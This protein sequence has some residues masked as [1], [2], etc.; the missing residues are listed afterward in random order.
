MSIWP[1]ARTYQTIMD[2]KGDRILL[3]RFPLVQLARTMLM[4][5]RSLPD[6]SLPLTSNA[7]EV[8]WK[9]NANCIDGRFDATFVQDC[10]FMETPEDTY[11]IY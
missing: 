8:W 3:S 9:A 4:V 6:Y 5:I 7:A 11:V 2:A 10:R 1:A